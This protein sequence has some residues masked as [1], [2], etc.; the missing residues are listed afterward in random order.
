MGG[1]LNPLPSG[2]RIERTAR[3]SVLADVRLSTSPRHGSGRAEQARNLANE[4]Q[5]AGHGHSEMLSRGYRPPDTSSVVPLSPPASSTSPARSFW[6]AARTA[7]TS[8]RRCPPNVDTNG[9]RPCLAY[10]RIVAVDTPRT[11]ATCCVV[12]GRVTSCTDL[13][14]QSRHGPRPAASATARALP[15]AR[16]GRDRWYPSMR[17]RRPQR[18]DVCA[19]TPAPTGHY[20]AVLGGRSDGHAPLSRSPPRGD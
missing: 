9:M 18:G 16:R 15:Q 5:I 3:A 10:R 13:P 8:N 1:R 19:D 12:A 17:P 6:S 20:E 7:S 11:V 2:R 14:Y 4:G